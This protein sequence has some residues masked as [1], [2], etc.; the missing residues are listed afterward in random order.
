MTRYLFALAMLLASPLSIAGPGAHGPNGE[1]LDAPA[2]ITTAVPSVPRLEASTESFELLARLYDEEFSVIVDRFETN[3]PVLKARIE[4]ETNGIKDVAKFHADHGDYSFTKPELL[5]A[6]RQ[7]GQHPIV[8]TVLT[9]SESDL[10][11]GTLN[12]GVAQEPGKALVHD[13]HQH[14]HVD[15]HAHEHAWQ[16]PAI[17]IA[18]FFLL[19]L[20]GWLF[21]RRSQS[22]N[23]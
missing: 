20:F 1:H 5:K 2:G 18:A 13:D 19:T 12:V 11:D 15:D 3:E 16:R 6:L 22:G 10:V 17:V 21:R 14:E 8:F 23:K 7:P 9:D 4:A